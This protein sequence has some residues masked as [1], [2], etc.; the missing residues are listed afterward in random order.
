[1]NS[2]RGGSCG[3]LG[4][5]DGTGAANT[6][7]ETEGALTGAARVGTLGDCATEGTGAGSGGGDTG[8][9]CV[10]CVCWYGH[11]AEPVVC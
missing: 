9:C 4:G 7:C 5:T 6:G 1:M 2:G 8:D 11:G 3:S 10:C